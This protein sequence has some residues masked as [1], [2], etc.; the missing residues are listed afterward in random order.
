M[1]AGG[2]DEDD[3][4][5]A[6]GPDPPSPGDTAAPRIVGR[7]S[8]VDHANAF[9]QVHYFL[10]KTP[11]RRRPKQKQSYDWLKEEELTTPPLR[12]AYA[13]LPPER[14]DI[15]PLGSG[16]ATAVVGAQG[17]RRVRRGDVGD[18]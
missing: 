15:D 10:V 2:D 13:L 6:R 16:W 7:A 9:R 5:A 18:A 12:A 3:A 17:Q 14:R 11:G 8:V 1:D 4:D